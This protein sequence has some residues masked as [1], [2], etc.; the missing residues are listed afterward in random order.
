MLILR[1]MTSVWKPIQL[2]LKWRKQ[3]QFFCNPAYKNSELMFFFF[4]FLLGVLNASFSYVFLRK[5]SYFFYLI[6]LQLFSFRIIPGPPRLAIAVCGARTLVKIFFRKFIIKSWS[7][8][9]SLECSN[10]R[11]IEFWIS[12]LR[13]LDILKH[14][15]KFPYICPAVGQ[16]ERILT[17]SVAWMYVTVKTCFCPYRFL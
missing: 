1:K 12:E 8:S 17:S 10:T 2:F 15:W 11:G 16:A 3:N 13:E 9:W 4:P 14:K 5:I 6:L 7:L